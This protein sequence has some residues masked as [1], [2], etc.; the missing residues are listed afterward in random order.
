MKPVAFRYL[1]T[2]KC[3]SPSPNIAVALRSFRWLVFWL[4][5]PETPR[6]CSVVK[7]RLLLTACKY[8]GRFYLVDYT[9]RCSDHFIIVD[10]VIATNKWMRG[11]QLP[12]SQQF[13]TQTAPR[14]KAI[15]WCSKAIRAMRLLKGGSRVNVRPDTL[16]NTKADQAIPILRSESLQ[17]PVIFVVLGDGIF[18]KEELNPATIFRFI[19]S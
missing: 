7:L 5:L 12:E 1:P 10:H 13:P 18:E 15:G 8:I 9:N 14:I 2:I 16:I 4:W 19:S 11:C 3:S 6:V 17:P